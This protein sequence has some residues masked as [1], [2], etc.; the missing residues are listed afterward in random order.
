MEFGGLYS[1]ILKSMRIPLSISAILIATLCFG[2]EGP[3]N[4][5]YYPKG[6][7][8]EEFEINPIDSSKNGRYSRYNDFSKLIARGQ[9]KNGTKNGI[10]EFYFYNS[11]RDS[12]RLLERYNYD[13]RAQLSYTYR[14]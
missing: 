13:T 1:H 12:M 8:Y 3:I 5:T 4:K 6:A 2:Q 9:Y 14:G 10:W 11:P 7:V